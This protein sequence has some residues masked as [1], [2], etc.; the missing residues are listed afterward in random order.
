MRLFLILLCVA[1]VLGMPVALNA[2]S[3]D[4]IDD[5][6]SPNLIGITTVLQGAIQ[7][8][9]QHTTPDG[10][11]R[12]ASTGFA[13]ELDVLYRLPISTFALDVGIGARYL[14]PRAV[15][16]N[17]QYSFLPL[18]AV[19]QLPF[20]VPSLENALGIYVDG[21]IGYSFFLPAD[22]YKEAYLQETDVTGGLFFGFGLGIAYHINRRFHIRA[23]ALYSV[24][25]ATGTN[26]TKLEEGVFEA[27]VGVGFTL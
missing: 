11:G 8:I 18:Y 6:E 26:N 22:S 17:N 25:N 27:S 9:V 2:Q 13:V 10:V 15:D 3:P 12:S 23:T 1:A 5:T 24:S 20:S 19:I 21:R 16:G 4:I 7:P 14:F